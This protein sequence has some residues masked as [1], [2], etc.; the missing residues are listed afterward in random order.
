MNKT[1]N[2]MLALTMC[3]AAVVTTSCKGNDPEVPTQQE[4]ETKIIGKWKSIQ[5][6]GK[7]NLT[8]ERM[9]ATFFDNG[10]EERS[11]S[12]YFEG[13]GY[14]WSNKNP[15]H[16]EIK[17]NSLTQKN[18]KDNMI[19]YAKVLS[20]NNNSLNYLTEKIITEKGEEIFPNDNIFFQKVTADYSQDIIGMWEGVEMTGDETYGD[21]NHRIE[22][23]AD[24]T[25]VYYDK[26]G[27]DW[28]LSEDVDNEYNVDGDWLA[29]RWRPQAGADYEYEWWDIVEI[30][31]GTMKW[32]A[33][34]EKEDKTRFTTTFTWKKVN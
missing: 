13:V 27:D 16:Y 3:V 23:K 19:H 2:F 18:L 26:D 31:D 14:L 33:L 15:Y 11:A 21:A 5:Q 24:G 9:T 17:G 12:R 10:K 34:R 4:I 32:S 6:N 22:Y 20:I 1:F 30:K 28:K 25:Y 29:S 7:D 8:N